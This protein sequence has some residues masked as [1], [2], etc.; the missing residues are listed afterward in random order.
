MGGKMEDWGSPPPMHLCGSLFAERAG[1]HRG[2]LPGLPQGQ[3][4]VGH[5]WPKGPELHYPSLQV[6]AHPGTLPWGGPDGRER[7]PQG[8]E[9]QNPARA[10]ARGVELSTWGERAVTA[11]KWGDASLCPLPHFCCD[12]GKGKHR[13]R[14]PSWE[15]S[16]SHSL[17]LCAGSCPSHKA[18]GSLVSI[19][20]QSCPKPVEGPAQLRLWSTM[21]STP[22]HFPRLQNKQGSICANSEASVQGL[23]RGRSGAT[24]SRAILGA[25]LSHSGTFSPLPALP[26][27]GSLVSPI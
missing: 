8:A 26:R 24:A 2:H 1:L 11:G 19:W 14:A 5:R 4:A 17:A 27:V 9:P 7:S 21:I 6:R 20:Q 25:A 18:P 3:R 15:P 12:L 16:W 13:S 22:K 10:W 23:P